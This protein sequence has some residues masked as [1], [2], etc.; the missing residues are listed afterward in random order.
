MSPLSLLELDMRADVSTVLSGT[1]RG[2]PPESETERR[3][4]SSL[5]RAKVR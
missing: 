3:E 4:R 1:G 2:T 5:A